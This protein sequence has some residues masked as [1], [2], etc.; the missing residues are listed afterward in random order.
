MSALWD[1]VAGLIE[2]DPF[3]TSLGIRLVEAAEGRIVIEMAV[4]ERHLNF[5]GGCHGGA[6]FSVADTA[7]GL[8]SNAGG[9]ISIGIDTHMAYIRG[10]RAG[11]R[12]T[13]TA[14]EISRSRKTGVY[15]VDVSRD[16]ET[17]ATFTGTVHI[18]GRTWDQTVTS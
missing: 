11:D 7:F 10:V 15:R 18:T 17:V 2:N 4:A 14:E 3:V 12:L 16:D 5:N 9:V 1:H 6:I 8:A 13:A